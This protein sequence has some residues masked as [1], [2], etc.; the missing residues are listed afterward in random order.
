MRSGPLARAATGGGC[1]PRRLGVHVGPALHDGAVTS[2]AFRRAPAWGGA[3]AGTVCAVYGADAAAGIGVD[4]GALE[5]DEDGASRHGR[6]AMPTSTVARG[7][8]AAGRRQQR[9]G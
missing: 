2:G 1:L 3:A 5:A 8:A 6:A 9:R 7:D 4:Q